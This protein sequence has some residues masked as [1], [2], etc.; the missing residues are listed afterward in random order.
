MNV[1]KRDQHALVGRN[2][3]AGNTSHCLF[4]LLP[5]MFGSGCSS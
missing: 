5:E 1:L 3:D 2:V 4:L